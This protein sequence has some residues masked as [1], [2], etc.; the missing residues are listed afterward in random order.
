MGVAF[1]VGPDLV[2]LGYI[3]LSLT[4][5]SNSEAAPAQTYSPRDISIAH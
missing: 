2:I 4:S 5:D 3:Y 1:V